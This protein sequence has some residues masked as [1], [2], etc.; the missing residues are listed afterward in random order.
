MFLIK[1]GK[2]Y[3]LS[4]W[5]C[6]WQDFDKV[7]E[8]NCWKSECFIYHKCNRIIPAKSLVL[9]TEIIKKKSNRSHNIFFNYCKIVYNDY[10]CWIRAS[11]ILT[12]ISET[13]EIEF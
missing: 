3:K 1:Q 8:E 6:C 2:L 12:N 10:S 5:T 4:N 7:K 9:V 13:E 11:A